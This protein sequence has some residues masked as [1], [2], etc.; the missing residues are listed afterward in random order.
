MAHS[1]SSCL[2]HFVFSTRRRE[3]IIDLQWLDRLW[4][5]MGGI[6]RTDGMNA[7]C[8]GGTENHSHLLLLMPPTIAPAK[9][10][11]IIK[12]NSS[13]WVN[14]TIRPR[15]DFSWQ[16][17]YGV[18]TIGYS[19]IEKTRNYIMGQR[20]HHRIKT[21]EEEYRAFLKKHMIEYHEDYVWG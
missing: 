17:G 20:E 14:E 10:I 11:Q 1:Y 19:Q 3:K 21:F 4:E 8:V 13:K 15:W 16:E 6:A 12:G 2:Y 5:Y 7:L 9:G 18:F